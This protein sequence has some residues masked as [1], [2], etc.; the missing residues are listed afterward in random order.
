M[1]NGGKE[2][3]S[4]VEG[5]RWKV[6]FQNDQRAITPGQICVIYDGDRVVGSGVI[7]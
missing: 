5:G 2:G 4:V 7:V 1:S 3:I 6:E